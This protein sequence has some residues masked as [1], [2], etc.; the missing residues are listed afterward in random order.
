LRLYFDGFFM[1]STSFSTRFHARLRCV[2]PPL[3]VALLLLGVWALLSWLR[4]FPPSLVPPPW[5]MTGAS[6]A[7]NALDVTAP[8]N[9][10]EGFLELLHSGR[11]FDDTIASLFRV[12][13][14]FELAVLAG[15]PLG[16]WLGS[17]SGARRAL[18]PGVNFFRSLSP[19][20]WIGFAILWFGIGDASSIFLIFMATFFP[21]VLATV[22]AVSSIPT[23]YFRVARDYGLRGNQLLGQVVLPAILP[24][25]IVALRVTAGVAWVVVVAAEMNGAQQGLGFAIHDARNA[26]RADLLVVGMIIIGLVGLAMDSILA[27]LSHLP[28]VRWGYDR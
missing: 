2:A 25:L 9:V 26:L 21:I 12:A 22:A 14:G 23:V 19:I 18:L 3:G 6:S 24:Q 15:V 8:D 10:W 7:A 13:V 16:L 11:L 1:T 28:G 5:N 27:R 20:A 17:A 4:V